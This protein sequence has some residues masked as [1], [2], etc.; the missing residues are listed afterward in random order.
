MSG[1]RRIALTIQLRLRPKNST[2]RTPLPLRVTP[3]QVI[4]NSL[5]YVYSNHLGF[6]TIVVLLSSSM[7][8]GLNHPLGP[9]SNLRGSTNV[10]STLNL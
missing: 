10:F 4:P 9:V 1:E 5:F 7:V 6:S 2:I 8:C 3:Y